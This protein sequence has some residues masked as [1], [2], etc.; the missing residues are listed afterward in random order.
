M[1]IEIILNNI[2]PF[3]SFKVMMM[4]TVVHVDV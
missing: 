4:L 3:L 2:S 1:K